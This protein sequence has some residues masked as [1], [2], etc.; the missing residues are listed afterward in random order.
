MKIKVEGHSNLYKDPETNV[1]VNRGTTER[2]RYQVA[3][4]QAQANIDSKYEIDALRSEI[5][6]IKSLLKQVLQQR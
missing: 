3:K 6:E 1:I 4:Q 5:D 2:S